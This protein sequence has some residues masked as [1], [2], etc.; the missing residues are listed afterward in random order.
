MKII[1]FLP[2]GIILFLDL[3]TSLLSIISWVF[4]LEVWAENT[5]FMVLNSNICNRTPLTRTVL[6]VPVY[7]TARTAFL[8]IRSRVIIFLFLT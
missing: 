4:R 2:S 1:I 3:L 5:M 8:L 6:P 7:P